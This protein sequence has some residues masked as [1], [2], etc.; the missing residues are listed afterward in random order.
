[1]LGSGSSEFAR[2]AH[3]DEILLQNGDRISGRVVSEE[4]QFVVLDHPAMGRVQIGKDFIRQMLVFVET[5][6]DASAETEMLNPVK[7]AQN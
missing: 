3:A 7:S 1:M 2:I 4:D 5:A 6:R